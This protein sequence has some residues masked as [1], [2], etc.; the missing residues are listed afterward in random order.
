MKSRVAIWISATLNLSIPEKQY[1]RKCKGDG[2]SG[3]PAKV[4]MLEPPTNLLRSM[5]PVSV[6]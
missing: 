3:R 5:E 1:K 4:R 6:V 2:S